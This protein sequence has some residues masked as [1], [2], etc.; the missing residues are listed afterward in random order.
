MHV[1]DNRID[2]SSASPANEIPPPEGIRVFGF[3]GPFAIIRAN[4]VSG[5]RIGI[6]FS[7]VGTPLPQR[8][9]W[10]IADNFAEKAQE[11]LATPSATVRSKIR[12]AADNYA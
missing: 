9:Q 2:A 4:H 11:V 3:V 10:V 1:L 12:G 6:R 7:P 5:L 8:P